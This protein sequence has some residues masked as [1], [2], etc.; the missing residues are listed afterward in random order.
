VFESTVT[1]I[2]LTIERP[3]RLPAVILL[4]RM[5][6]CEAQAQ[7]LPFARPVTWMPSRGAPSMLRL[8]TVTSV[9]A[10]RTP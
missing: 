9:P 4:W 2:P 6:T 3:F 8:S 5:T 1:P 7:L 10:T